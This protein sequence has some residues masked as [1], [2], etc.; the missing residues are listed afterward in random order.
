MSQYYRLHSLRIQVT[1]DRSAIQRRLGRILRYKGAEPTSP[2]ENVDVTL[3]F[4]VDRRGEV[5]LPEDAHLVDTS[6]QW[7]IEIWKRARRMILRCGQTIVR[8]S[9]GAGVARA[10]IVPEE[11]EGESETQRTP[12]FDL[13]LLSLTI[14]L[15]NQGRFPL[16]AAALVWNG[17]GILLPGESGDGKSTTGLSLVRR[18]WDYLSDDTVLLRSEEERIDVYSF[19]RHF[20]VDP[21]ATTFFPALAGPDWSPSLSDASKWQVDPESVYPGSSVAT[22]TP[23]VIALPT[24]VGGSES[25]VE[26]VGAKPVLERLIGQG[27]FLLTANPKVAD[28]HLAVL[29]RL[30]RQSDTCRFYAGRDILEDPSAAHAFLAPLLGNAS[31]PESEKLRRR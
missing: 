25:R 9:P 2:P 24:I 30:I 3:D 18:G 20:C 14:L 13:T 21:E 11:V 6:T 28:R 1:S 7:G 22:C 26:P 12:L 17:K 8:I 16:H 29:R 5:G 10:V 27:A 19:R 31:S 15:R 23:S 4:R